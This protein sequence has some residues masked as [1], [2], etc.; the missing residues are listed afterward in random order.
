[1]M[2][3]LVTAFALGLSLAALVI[4]GSAKASEKGALSDDELSED[5]I[6]ASSSVQER[7][8]GTAEASPGSPR[9]PARQIPERG[10]VAPDDDLGAGAAISPELDSKVEALLS[11]ARKLADKGNYAEAQRVL[12]EAD[13]LSPMDDRVLDL[14]ELVGQLRAE[15]SDSRALLQK[16][17]DEERAREETLKKAGSGFDAVRA[18]HGLSKSLKESNQQLALKARAAREQFEQAK[19]AKEACIAGAVL[20]HAAAGARRCSSLVKSYKAAEKTLRLIEDDLAILDQAV[21]RRFGK[22]ALA[23]LKRKQGRGGSKA[24]SKG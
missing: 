9:E 2:R 7:D 20:A 19:R 11:Q 5:L 22:K 14:V 3:A 16:I 24:P 10:P 15:K 6:P 1:M 4:A 13:D 12:T 23:K 21:G 8:R 18:R 17:R